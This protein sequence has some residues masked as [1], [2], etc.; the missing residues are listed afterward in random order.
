MNAMEQFQYFYEPQPLTV[1]TIL[2]PLVV[3][4]TFPNISDWLQSSQ[5]L[6][7]VDASPVS[8]VVL[9]EQF[10]QDILGDLGNAWN[11]FIESGQVWALLVGFVLGYL[12]RGITTYQ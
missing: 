3:E 6:A 1:D 4:S 2:R 10:D 5:E 9:A 8:A 11:T 12:I 7:T